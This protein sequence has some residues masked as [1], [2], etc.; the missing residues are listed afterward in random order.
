VLITGSRHNSFDSDPWI[1]K[2]VEFTKTVLEQRRVR[3]ISVY[4]AHQIVGRAIGAKVNR[5]DKG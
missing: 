4:F 5:S 3:I 1:L 2:L